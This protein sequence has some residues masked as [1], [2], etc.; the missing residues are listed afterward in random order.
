MSVS[1]IEVII[2]QWYPV[3]LY[4]IGH[5]LH[6]HRLKFNENFL[7]IISSDVAFALL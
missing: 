4:G 1:E 3:V 5:G 6:R 2:S 7:T